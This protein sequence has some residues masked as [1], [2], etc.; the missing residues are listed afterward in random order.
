MHIHKPKSWEGLREFLKEYLI[1]VVGVLTALALEQTV[2]A[3][4][5]AHEIGEGRKALGRE[6]GY[7]LKA[8]DLVSADEDPCLGPYLDALQ[9]WAEGGPRPAGAIRRPVL[10]TLRTSTW[11]VVNSGQV[12]AHFPLDQKDRF[13]MAY[14]SILN[15]RDI[16]AD[17]RNVWET[18]AAVAAG[19][20]LEDADR[21]ELRHDIGMAR[22]LDGRRRGNADQVRLH[23]RG[24]ATDSL[25]PDGGDPAAFCRAPATPGGNDTRAH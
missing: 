6:I 18:I 7:D 5:W 16:I 11:D 17:E 23:A 13:A 8:L 2:E 22:I 14:G 1:I 20:V 12:V 24:L 10:Y 25:G 4:H 21:R 15:E 9:R 19:P 3:V